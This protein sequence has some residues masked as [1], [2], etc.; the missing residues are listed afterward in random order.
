MREVNPLIIPRNHKVEEA[1]KEAEIDDNLPKLLNLLRFLKNP[2]SVQVGI[3]EFQIPSTAEN[4]D[5]KT[6]CGT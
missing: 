6:F 5:Y 2:Y 3:D 4:S 1:L